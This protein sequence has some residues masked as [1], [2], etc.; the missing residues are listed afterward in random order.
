MGKESFS[1]NATVEYP[2]EK[3]MNTDPSLALGTKTTSKQSTNQ[4]V[5]DKNIKLPEENLEYLLTEF[6]K[7]LFNV[8]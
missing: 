4:N 5:S 8:T 3:K 6:R 2:R 1:N 7:N